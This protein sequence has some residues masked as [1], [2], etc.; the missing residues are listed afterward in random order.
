MP[1]LKGTRTAEFVH[2][3]AGSTFEAFFEAENGALFRRMWLITGSRAEAEEIMQEAFLR[4]LPR[5]ERIGALTD[6]SGYLYRTAFNV[7]RSRARRTRLALKKIVS[8]E[9]EGD[10]FA[11]AEARHVLA[12]AM[13]TLSTRQR[14][15]LVL[16]E[17][18]GFEAPEAGRLLGVRPS[19]VRSLASQGRAAI[20]RTLGAQDD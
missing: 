8:P 13:R 15:A 4:L 3:S 6:P 5:W 7:L 1:E 18:L 16:T 19:T 17:L 20:R 9:Q 11:A 10:E 2:V 12:G 14:A